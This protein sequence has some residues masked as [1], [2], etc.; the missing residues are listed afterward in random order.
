[1]KHYSMRNLIV[2]FAVASMLLL[3]GCGDDPAPTETPTLAPPTATSHAVVPSE[4]TPP[5]TNTLPAPAAATVSVTAASPIT[6]AITDAAVV[7]PTAP[8]GE[9]IVCSTEPNADLAGYGD[10]IARLGCPVADATFD[11]VAINEFGAGPDYDR[12]M[13]WFSSEHQIYVL[14]QDHT[15]LAYTDTWSESEPEI[16]CNPDKGPET[17]PPL[18]R[19]G[20]GKLWCTVDSV[21]L[22]L[23]TIDREERLCQHSAVQR[24]ERG[25]LLACFE[26]ATIR[27]YRILDDGKWDMERVQ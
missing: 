10:L 8:S 25:R 6:T 14:F 7:T 11:P 20:F 22:Q 27:Y 1:M 12:F 2:V 23:G 21:R 3:A 17:S 24:F 16:L 9:P 19:R 5:P 15:W 18:P 4:P 13:L 26:D